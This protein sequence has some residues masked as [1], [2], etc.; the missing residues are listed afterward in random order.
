[1]LQDEKMGVVSLYGPDFADKVKEM[2]PS[3]GV[4]EQMCSLYEMGM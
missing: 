1:M 3:E 4:T 2:C